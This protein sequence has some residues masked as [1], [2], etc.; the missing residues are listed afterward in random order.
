MELQGIGVAESINFSQLSPATF[1]G[2]N[3]F[4][5]NERKFMKRTSSVALLIATTIAVSMS[6][7]AQ[8]SKTAENPSP[9]AAKETVKETVNY[10]VRVQWKTEK[11]AISQLQVLTTEGN[12]SLNT[13]LPEP[14]KIN[15]MDI[16]STVNLKGELHVL[17]PEKGKI[18]LFL[19]RTVP[20][21]TS[22]YGTDKNTNA[23][24]QQLSVGLNSTFTVTFGK[25]LVIQSDGKE[26]ISIL[27]KR[28]EN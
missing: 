26:E 15:G 23:S 17:S 19:G 24:Y 12:F 14:V 10:I 16:P 9:P 21:V 4:T 25:P 18:S 22:T 3:C 13:L 28:D 2:D 1:S 11:G 5:Y 20:Y 7:L 8:S 27:V 6:A